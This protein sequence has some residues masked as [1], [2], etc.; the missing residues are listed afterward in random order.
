MNEEGAP[1]SRT[2]G[3]SV[4]LS[5][6]DGYPFGGVVGALIAANLVQVSNFII[7]SILTKPLTMVNN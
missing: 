6:P 4:S 3:I 1:K 7:L 5:H 2:G